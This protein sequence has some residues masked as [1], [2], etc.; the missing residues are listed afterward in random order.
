MD[1]GISATRSQRARRVSEV[2]D[3]L[4]ALRI[5]AGLTQSQLAGGR[6]SKEYVSQIER[7]KTHPSNE[8]LEWLAARLD[9]DAGYLLGGVTAEER[10]RVEAALARAEALAEQGEHAQAARAFSEGRQVVAATGAVDLELR[11]LLG[12]T[13][14]LAQSGG[15][16]EA[17]GLL[18]R[19]RDITEN[20][21][22]SD[23]DR[24]AVLLRLGVCRYH[25]SSISSAVALLT[26]ALELADRSGLPCDLLRVHILDWRSRC[27]RRQRDWLAAREDVERALELAESARDRRA[28]ARAYFQ[29]SLVAEREGHWL[30]ARTYAERAR[31]YYEELE[32]RANVGRLLNNLGGLNFT[33][34]NAARAVELLTGAHDVALEVGDEPEAGLSMCSLAQVHLDVSEPGLAEDEAS[35]ALA[36]F[37]DRPDYLEGIGTAQLVLGRALLEQDRLEEAEGMLLAADK[38]FEQLSSV[39]NRA[40]AWVAQGDL[41]QKRNA[42]REAARLYRRAAEALQDFRF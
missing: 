42:D 2:G 3:R 12:E 5:S 20:P 7:G 10:G 33:L 40:A 11:S 32:D 36:L 4:R 35:K 24:A 18:G 38:S 9:T 6:F 30:L 8:T 27:Y 22:F 31:G 25:L 17:L 28:S 1:K 26:S 29:A 21:Q 15:I 41:A 39:S 37:D 16:Q 34:G 23:V 13:L 19:A 14:A